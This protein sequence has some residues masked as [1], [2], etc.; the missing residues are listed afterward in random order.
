MRLKVL[1]VAMVFVC[2]LIWVGAAT[3]TPITVIN[4]SFEIDAATDG[5]VNSTVTGWIEA[6][7]DTGTFDPL[8]PSHF[9]NIPDGEQVAYINLNGALTQTVSPLTTLGVTYTLTTAIGNRADACCA[10][11]G[12][13][14]LLINGIAV[15]T[16]AGPLPGEGL[17]SD[18][19]ASYLA[20][21]SG[22]SIGIRLFNVSNT[23]QAN[24]DDVRLNDSNVASVPEPMTLALLG[25]GLVGLAVKS[26]KRTRIS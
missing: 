21:V 15:A 4:P 19:T 20:P 7:G 18:Y 24:F 2:S 17:W 13:I 9:S 3:A 14:Q 22:Q 12:N 6:P 25:T 1:H 23:L 8:V 11:T 10:P 26:R 16:G 5:N